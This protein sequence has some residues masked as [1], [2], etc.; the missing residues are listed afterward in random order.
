V[1]LEWRHFPRICVLSTTRRYLYFS[2]PTKTIYYGERLQFVSEGRNSVACSALVK[3]FMEGSQKINCLIDSYLIRNINITPCW[4][5]LLSKIILSL[6][7]IQ[8]EINGLT[9]SC[10]FCCQYEK[11]VKK[12]DLNHWQSSGIWCP[13]QRAA[14]RIRIDFF[15]NM[16]MCLQH[17]DIQVPRIIMP[18]QMRYFTQSS[19][20]FPI[21]L[22][23]HGTESFCGSW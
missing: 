15:Q 3:S 12:S 11:E 6:C 23:C 20:Y 9:G 2:S 4:C 17:N 13:A 19:R 7:N 1:K 8:T 22:W 18:N 16:Q 10:C 5:I 21:A 14:K